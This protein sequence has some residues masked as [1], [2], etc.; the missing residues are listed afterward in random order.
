M[1]APA[2]KGNTVCDSKIKV[3]RLT[4]SNITYNGILKTSTRLAK[5]HNINK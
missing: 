4:E 5:A 3:T 1:T 2:H